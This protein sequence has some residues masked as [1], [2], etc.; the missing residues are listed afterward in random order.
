MLSSFSE[1]APTDGVA[2]FAEEFVLGR[3]A[4]VYSGPK[5]G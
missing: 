1:S 5:D 4:T 3:P 2:A